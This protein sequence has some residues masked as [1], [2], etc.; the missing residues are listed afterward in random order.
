MKCLH[1]YRVQRDRIFAS[2]R[3]PRRLVSSWLIIP[4]S[5]FTKD[6]LEKMGFRKDGLERRVHTAD[7]AERRS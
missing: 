6:D 3:C 1:T 7:G 4:S 5:G 2:L